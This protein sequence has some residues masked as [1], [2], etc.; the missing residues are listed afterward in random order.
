[1]LK[2]ETKKYKSKRGNIMTSKERVRTSFAHK[3]PDKM[4][5]DFGG[6]G[7]STTHVT[8]VKN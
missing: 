6:M 8:N 4:A 5:M 3:Q 1:M 2:D 7:C